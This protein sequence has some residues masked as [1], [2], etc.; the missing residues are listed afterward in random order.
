MGTN[1]IPTAVDGTTIPASNHNSLKEAMGNDLVPRNTSGVPTDLEGDIGTDALRF[2]VAKIASGYFFAG[3]I[4][5]FHSYNATL[6]PGHGW[7]KCDGRIVN[8]TNYDA[9]YASGDWT[10]YIK[11]SDIDGLYL[12]DLTGDKYLSGVAATTQDG[13]IALT[14]VGTTSKVVNLQHSHTV[15]SHNHE[16]YDNNGGSTAHSFDSSGSDKSIAA[17]GGSGLG[18]EAN[19]GILVMSTGFHTSNASPG[20]DNQLSATQTIQPRSIEVIYYMRII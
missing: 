8:S 10:K 19:S 17:S 13:S 9:E 18:I 15:D 5:P 4:L 12:P 16:W 7:M 11:N 1:N 20:T 6:T 2:L 3:Q 14:E